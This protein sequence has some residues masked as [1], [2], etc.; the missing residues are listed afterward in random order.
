[1]ALSEL[2]HQREILRL[3]NAHPLVPTDELKFRLIEIA[4]YHLEY[5]EA[6]QCPV[7]EISPC[8]LIALIREIIQYRNKHGLLEATSEEWQFNAHQPPN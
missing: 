5:G 4:E 1:M 2:E 7:M 6:E 3:I 8:V